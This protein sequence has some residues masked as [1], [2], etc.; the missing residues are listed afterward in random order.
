MPRRAPV[1]RWDEL[2]LE[3]VTEMV[4]RK[5]IAGAGQTMAQ[6]WFKKGALVSRHSHASEQMTCVLDGALRVMVD[7]DEQVVR[8]GE[9]IVIPAGAPHQ[10]EALDDALVIDTFSPARE[11]WV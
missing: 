9:V 4:T 3:K 8:A 1:T 10:I 2:A 7:G 11:N 6:V 5:V